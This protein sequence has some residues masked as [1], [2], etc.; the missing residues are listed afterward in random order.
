MSD[1]TGRILK[2]KLGAARS[3]GYSFPLQSRL[4]SVLEYAAAKGASAALGVPVEATVTDSRVGTLADLVEG[5]PAPGLYALLGSP[6]G[7]TGLV[8]LE[9][10]LVD[11]LVDILSG[12][13]PD[14][15]EAAAERAPTAVDSALCLRVVGEVMAG[16]QAQLGA[17]AG[18]LEPAPLRPARVEHVAASLQFLL[19]D[20]KYLVLRGHLDIGD[21][22]RAGGLEL[23]LPLGWLE[24]VEEAVRR[25]GVAQAAGESEH[26]QRHMREVVRVTPLPLRA[27]IDR[28]RMSVA[29]LSRLKVGDVLRLADTTLE[30]VFLELDAPGHRRRIAHGRLGAWKR[31]K[32]LKLADPP[33]RDFLDP[34]AGALGLEAEPD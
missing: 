34:L 8:G 1:Q 33:D 19:A 17:L 10:R 3:R 24:P 9:M 5:L 12:G 15:C 30:D 13:D 25:L 29:E 22:P 20:R 16:L 31:S 28:C 11:H 7:D 21:G 4:A 14:A 26:W 32:A 18:D 27:V 2:R 6:A 23:A